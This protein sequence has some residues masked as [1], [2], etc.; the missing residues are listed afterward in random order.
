MASSPYTLGPLT[1]HAAD[2]DAITALYDRIWG[3]FNARTE[4]HAHLVAPGFAGYVVRDAGGALVG[5]GYGITAQPGDRAIARI[6][7]YLTPDEADCAL[8]NSFF[9]AEL[10]IAPEHHRRGLGVRL[11]R[12]TLAAC[13]HADATICTEHYN[14]PARGLYEGLG[15]VTLIEHMKFSPASTSPADDFIVYYTPLPLPG[16]TR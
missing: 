2:L 5:Y 11:M 1:D 12:A 6:A 9:V 14:A 15:F 16:T 10:A 13:G 4:V 7:T 3:R 8:F